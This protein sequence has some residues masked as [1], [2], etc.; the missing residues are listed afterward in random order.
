MLHVAAAPARWRIV[1]RFREGPTHGVSLRF[2]GRRG[3]DV[4]ATVAVARG[5][6]RFVAA[7]VVGCVGIVERSV[8]KCS[9]YLDD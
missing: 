1:F 3:R 2:R 4:G 5:L 7:W 9:E 8:L 6:F